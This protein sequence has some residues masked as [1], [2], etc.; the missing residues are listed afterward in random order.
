[1]MSPKK[2]TDSTASF[3]GKIY[4]NITET[5]GATPLVRLDK[6]AAAHNCNAQIIGKCEF[7]NP[8][9]SVKD[10]I[11]LNMIE[12]AEA[13]GR[14]KPDT[15]IVEPTSGNTGIGLAMVCA[16][17]GYRLIICL[18]ETHSEERRKM[19]LFL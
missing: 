14:I 7:F 16:S 15:V 9:G 17:K 10:R 13:D 5:I 18:P 3:R 1:M 6:L 8:L 19:L 12:A 4:N 2:P 11:G